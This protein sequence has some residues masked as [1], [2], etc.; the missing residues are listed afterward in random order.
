MSGVFL[1]STCVHTGVICG[2]GIAELANVESI[3]DFNV[4]AYCRHL[5]VRN[6]GVGEGSIE[7]ST[8][9]GAGQTAIVQ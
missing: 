6:C 1:I 9:C 3:L 4:G 5:G 8:R 7:Y 2:R